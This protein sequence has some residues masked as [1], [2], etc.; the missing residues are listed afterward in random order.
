MAQFTPTLLLTRPQMQAERF[1][2]IC[3]SEFGD[4]VK[5]IV[6]PVVQIKSETPD[7]QPERFEGFIFTS[8][9]AVLAAKNLWP[10][11]QGPAFCVGDRTAKVAGDAGYE[12]ISA[13]GTAE[14]LIRMIRELKPAGPL[15]HLRG[16]QTRGDIAQTLTKAGLQTTE[17]ILYRQV[18]A[19]LTDEAN[20]CLLGESL[21]ILP[22]FSPQGA[23]LFFK[24]VKTVTAPLRIVAL[25]EAVKAEISGSVQAKTVVSAHPGGLGMIDAIAGLID[26]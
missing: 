3:Q 12:S 10:H 15:L 1:A 25:S 24:Q 18:P 13:N 2:S 23:K 5:I 14:D 11:L 6:S 8:E 4:T 7:I 16:R 22:L 19:E 9:N 21:V 17:A 20:E 26:A